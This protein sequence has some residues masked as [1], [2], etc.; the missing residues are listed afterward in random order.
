MSTFLTVQ[1]VYHEE[2]LYTPVT[3][4][5]SDY[6]CLVRRDINSQSLIE[7]FVEKNRFLFYQKKNQEKNFWAVVKKIKAAKELPR[8]IVHS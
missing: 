7:N 2:I 3:M 8:S 5:L 1:K 6:I 4:G